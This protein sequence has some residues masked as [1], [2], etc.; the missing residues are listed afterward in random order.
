MSDRF[1][2]NFSERLNFHG[3]QEPLQK[4][5][6]IDKETVWDDHNSPF[7]IKLIRTNDLDEVKRLIGTDDKHFEDGTLKFAGT[8]LA[9]GIKEVTPENAKL[10]ASAYVFGNSQ[11]VKHLKEGIES[12]I[13]SATIQLAAPSEVV[14]SAPLVIKGGEV[15]KLDADIVT[16]KDKGQIQCEGT[17]SI[18][19]GLLRN[20]KQ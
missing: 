12:T 9:M 4:S 15:K 6:S 14:I 16:F 17:L 13:G 11:D 7:E 20:L 8:N 1:S 2:Q 10:A 18:S 5:V 19:A 3:V